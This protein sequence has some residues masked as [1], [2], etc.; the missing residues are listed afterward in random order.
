MTRI[1]LVPVQ[2]LTDQHLM[3]EYQ[4]L[5]RILGNVRKGIAAGKTPKNYKIPGEYVL[6]TGHMTF[7]YDKLEFLRKRQDEL[8]KELLNR[9]YNIQF[10][11]GLDLSEFPDYWCNDYEPTVKAI[12][13]SRSRIFEK[14]DLKPS[15]YKYWG[16]TFIEYDLDVVERV[17]GKIQLLNVEF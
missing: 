14:I 6:G 10:V 12:E 15:W 16:L 11:D 17:F 1:N 4:E 3:R 2:D 13:L 8:I 9:S 7:F 5:P